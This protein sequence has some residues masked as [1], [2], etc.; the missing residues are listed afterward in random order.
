MPITVPMP[1]G[2]MLSSDGNQYLDYFPPGYILTTDLGR[3]YTGDGATTPEA[4]ILSG[5]TGNQNNAIANLIP[6]AVAIGD[7]FDITLRGTFLNNSG[8]NRTVTLNVYYGAYQLVNVTSASTATG[9]SARTWAMDLR[10]IVEVVG[11]ANTGK[12]RLS[13][14]RIGCSTMLVASAGWSNVQTNALEVSDAVSSGT[15]ANLIT[16]AAGAFNVTAT[17]SNNANTITS[18]LNLAQVLWR[19]KNY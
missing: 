2:K 18:T 7:S 4:S 13:G 8:S 16:N 19:P 17:H 6:A 3:A 12:I 9:A 15:N 10:C 11:G 5:N 14:I 1:A